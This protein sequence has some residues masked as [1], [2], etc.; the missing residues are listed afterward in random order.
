MKVT[1]LIILFGILFALGLFSIL[2]DIFKLPSL[3]TRKA[4]LTATK[5]S[6]KKVKNIDAFISGLAVKLAKYIPVDEYKGKR[7]KIV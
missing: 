7:M 5:Q 4:M 2:A 6:G 1:F 3:A